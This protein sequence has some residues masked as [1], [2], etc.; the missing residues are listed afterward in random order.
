MHLVLCLQYRLQVPHRRAGTS[1]I[2]VHD[3]S[4]Q[5]GVWH[6]LTWRELSRRSVKESWQS[7]CLS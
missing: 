6:R 3:T 5:L 1:S 2:L 4:W 7:P